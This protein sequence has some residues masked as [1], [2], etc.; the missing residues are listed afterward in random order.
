MMDSVEKLVFYGEYWFKSVTLLPQN[1]NT[2][3]RFVAQSLCNE[4]NNNYEK[5]KLASISIRPGVFSPKEPMIYLGNKAYRYTDFIKTFRENMAATLWIFRFLNNEVEINKFG[6]YDFTSTLKELLQT[7]V[8]IICISEVGR[9]YSRAH[10]I[11]RDF[12]KE[13][14]NDEIGWDSLP[15]F[16]PAATTF[17]DDEKSLYREYE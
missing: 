9:G 11:V 2:D 13:V 5:M 15:S 17:A 4:I 16:F 14:Y 1:G 12:V 8:S 7:F 6:S 10:L 3:I